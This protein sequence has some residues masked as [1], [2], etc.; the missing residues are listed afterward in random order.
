M[1]DIAFKASTMSCQ[2]MK[3]LSLQ[4][5]DKN[6]SILAY[7]VVQPDCDKYMSLA[8]RD[9]ESRLQM[10][11]LSRKL[12]FTH[13]PSFKAGDYFN[14]IEN[15]RQES[16]E[17]WTRRKDISAPYEKDNKIIHDLDWEFFNCYK[18]VP[19]KCMLNTGTGVSTVKCPPKCSIHPTPCPNPIRY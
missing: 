2:A 9:A 10:N 19:E 5:W 11:G 6:S 3:E 16:Y 15:T 4:E 7:Q 18:N 1:N 8:D 14:Q 12:C 13:D 17:Q